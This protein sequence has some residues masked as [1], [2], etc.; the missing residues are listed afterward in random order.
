MAALTFGVC[1]WLLFS[2]SLE[3]GRKMHE[4]YDKLGKRDEQD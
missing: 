3:R 4:M 2:A 1:M